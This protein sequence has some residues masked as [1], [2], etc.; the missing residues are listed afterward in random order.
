[1]LLIMRNLSVKLL[2][3]LIIVFNRILLVMANKVNT[4]WFDLQVKHGNYL[5]KEIEKTLYEEQKEM[6][7]KHEEENKL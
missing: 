7:E 4:E 1:M 5:P 3:L 6:R 2:S